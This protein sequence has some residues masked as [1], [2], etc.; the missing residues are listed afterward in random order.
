VTRLLELPGTIVFQGTSA[1]MRSDFPLNLKEYGI[2]GLSK[3]LGMLK[4]HEN[5]E[6]H[7]DLVFSAGRGGLRGYSSA[8]IRGDLRAGPS[9]SKGP[10]PSAVRPLANDPHSSQT[11]DDYGAGGCPTGEPE[12]GIRKPQGQSDGRESEL[13]RRSLERNPSGSRPP[14]R[15]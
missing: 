2:G 10:S 11:G 8:R 6:V 7:V 15:P 5:I 14:F 1:R 12:R 4:M 3:M 13:T 9:V